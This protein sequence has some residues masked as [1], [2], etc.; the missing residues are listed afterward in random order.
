MWREALKRFDPVTQLVVSTFI[1]THDLGTR[2]SVL[3]SEL[4]PFDLAYLSF[5]TEFKC[6]IKYDA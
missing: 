4:S 2:Y 3:A 5:A 1:K 6:D